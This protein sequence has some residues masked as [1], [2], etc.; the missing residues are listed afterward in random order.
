M[1]FPCFHGTPA[2][3]SPIGE[4]ICND[5][6]SKDFY[7]YHF[8]ACTIPVDFY[9]Y[10]FIGLTAA[11]FV[12][13]LVFAPFLKEPKIQQRRITQLYLATVWINAI[14]AAVEYGQSGFFEGASVCI[15][16]CAAITIRSTIVV[17]LNMLSPIYA[18]ARRDIAPVR[19]SAER[20]FIAFT[21][22]WIAISIGALITC[23]DQD[24]SRFNTI[25][26]SGLI[27]IVVATAAFMFGLIK[28]LNDLSAIIHLVSQ[29]V[30]ANQPSNT[31]EQLLG[32]GRRLKFARRAALVTGAC[33]FTGALAMLIIWGVLGSIPYSFLLC[34]FSFQTGAVLVSPQMWLFLNKKTKTPYEIANIEESKAKK[35][36][37]N[38]SFKDL[39]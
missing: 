1:T 33:I 22:A 16:I 39:S 32:V 30:S 20:I 36:N 13:T 34:I 15:L 35:R 24:P 21:T 2:A 18:V 8:Q 38:K 37:F 5:S 9:F 23:R 7:I 29:N 4:C 31:R 17:A 28:A 19:Q 6:Y 25:V 26:S 27:L 11:A 3:D 10:L 14:W 12:V